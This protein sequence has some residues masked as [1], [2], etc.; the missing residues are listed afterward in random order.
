MTSGHVAKHHL[1]RGQH[2]EGVRILEEIVPLMK[3]KVGEDN[4]MT[5]LRMKNLAATYWKLNRLEQ[6]IPLFEELLA[7][8]EKSWGENIHRLFRR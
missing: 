7:L 5:L 6:S 1:D 4:A 3:A 8:E 2:E